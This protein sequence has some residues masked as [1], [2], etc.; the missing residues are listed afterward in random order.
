MNG[1]LTLAPGTHDAYAWFR[2]W[3]AFCGGVC[4]R[5]RDLAWEFGVDHCGR[6]QQP[7]GADDRIDAE[8]HAEWL[9]LRAHVLH[10]FAGHRE[11]VGTEAL[12]PPWREKDDTLCH[13]GRRSDVPAAL[14]QKSCGHAGPSQSAGRGGNRGGVAAIRRGRDG[15]VEREPAVGPGMADRAAQARAEEPL[16]DQDESRGFCVDQPE[17]RDEDRFAYIAKLEGDQWLRGYVPFKGKTGIVAGQSGMTVASGFDLG[18]WSKDE[19]KGLGLPS[20][21]FAQV[22]PFSAPLHFKKLKKLQVAEKVGK[23]APVPVLGKPSADL[24]DGAVFDREMKRAIAK[25]DGNKSDNVPSFRKL[26]SAWQT[27]WLSFFYYLDLVNFVD[28]AVVG[29]WQ[30]A[31]QALRTGTT[32]KDRTTQEANLLPTKLPD[33]VKQP[34]AG[35][36]R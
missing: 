7:N 11:V 2:P 12:P 20:D 32:Y 35:A 18:Q 34:G 30:A 16:C 4:W 8:E 9:W 5:Y 22:L 3:R 28:L 15:F 33:P 25:W 26:P 1:V 17:V 6:R 19:L 27:V 29:Q 14:Q 13:S 10:G 21:V 36:K 24:C 23:T 31:I